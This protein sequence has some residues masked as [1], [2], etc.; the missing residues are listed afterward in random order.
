MCFWLLVKILLI[1]LSQKE[2]EDLQQTQY[3]AQLHSNIYPQLSPEK[4]YFQ[5]KG[6]LQ[7]SLETR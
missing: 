4:E 5:I 7:F 1:T 2:Y 6:I 3:H